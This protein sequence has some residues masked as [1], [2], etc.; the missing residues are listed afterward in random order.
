MRL[1]PVS[2]KH[3]SP[4]STPT[5]ESLYRRQVLI[6]PLSVIYLT[7]TSFSRR[8]GADKNLDAYSAFAN[9]TDPYASPSGSPLADALRAQ[10]IGTLYVVGLATDYCVRASALDA[11]KAGFEVRVIQEGVR[12]VGGEQA[13]AKA[14]EELK[15]AGAFIVE[16]KSIE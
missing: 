4:G 5:E 2:S 13:T 10:D 9:P 1:S 7:C 14:E 6:L 11:C 3:F 12:A 15:N 8:Q 16:V